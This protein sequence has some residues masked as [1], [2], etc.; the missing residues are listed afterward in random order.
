VL[1]VNKGT[2]YDEEQRWRVFENRVLRRILRTK[3][4]ELTGGCKKTA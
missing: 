4:D 3:R 2:A 1:K